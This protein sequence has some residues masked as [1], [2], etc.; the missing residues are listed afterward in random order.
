M[1]DDLAKLP[2]DD[3][4]EPKR[5]GLR[6]LRKA[7]R[8]FLKQ[9]E[10]HG[11]AAAGQPGGSRKKSAG[12]AATGATADD[13]CQPQSTDTRGK[14]RQ[15]V[16]RCWRMS[17][18]H[19]LARVV[20]AART[21][22]ASEEPAAGATAG[23]S[24]ALRFS[25]VL[26]ELGADAAKATEPAAE[27]GKST[28]EAPATGGGS[29]GNKVGKGGKKAKGGGKGK[30]AASGA[31]ADVQEESDEAAIARKQKEE[32]VAEVRS[33]TEVLREM[34][35]GETFVTTAHRAA[36]AARDTIVLELA[37]KTKVGGPCIWRCTGHWVLEVPW[38]QII[39]RLPTVLN[40]CH[41]MVGPLNRASRWMK[42]VCPRDDAPRN[43]ARRTEPS[44]LTRMVGKACVPPVS[45][46]ESAL[47][48][49]P[50][51][52]CHFAC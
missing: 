22:V 45:P 31:A 37:D 46:Q 16:R 8:V 43:G 50:T 19:D 51:L 12:S 42:V 1:A 38:K 32:R 24:T 3:D 47:T 20:L 11:S 39:S 33:W 17:G 7:E 25:A 28:V 5:R 14:G 40:E 49:A 6:R 52:N 21:I 9:Q 29:G 4:L 41:C 23:N 2:G 34:L 48:A 26:E 27:D 44:S 18:L 13:A 10:Q 35:E 15:W 36:V 30:E